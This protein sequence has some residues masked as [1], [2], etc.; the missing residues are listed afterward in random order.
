[1][2]MS[3]FDRVTKSTNVSLCTLIAPQVKERCIRQTM[4]ANLLA[5]FNNI[6]AFLIKFRFAG[7]GGNGKL[8]F[9]KE[10]KHRILNVDEMGISVNGSK[11]RVGGRPKISFHNPHLPLPSLSSAKS[12]HSCTGI[13]GSNAA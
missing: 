3:I 10:M 12:L 9:D 6:K 2:K 8:V 13:F 5:W 1:M 11:T 7:V 4:Y